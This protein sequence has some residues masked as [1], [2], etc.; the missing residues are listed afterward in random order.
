MLD[1][2]LTVNQSYFSYHTRVDMV[3]VSIMEEGLLRDKHVWSDSHC[4]SE[5]QCIQR[6]HDRV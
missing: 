2:E 3:N 4:G 6:G 1:N 5:L